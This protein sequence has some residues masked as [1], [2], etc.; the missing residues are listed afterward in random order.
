MHLESLQ[1]GGRTNSL[2]KTLAHQMAA[3]H[4]LGMPLLADAGENLRVYKRTHQPHRSVEA[5]R[6]ANMAARLMDV[7]QRGLLTLD[8]IR[9]GGRQNAVVQHVNVAT[10]GQAVVPGTVDNR[11]RGDTQE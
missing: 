1:G 5:G 7:Y 2:E 9:N 6:M 3:M 8:R 10:G 11:H 4:S